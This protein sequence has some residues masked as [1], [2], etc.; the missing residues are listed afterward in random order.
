MVNRYF[1]IKNLCTA[2]PDEELPDKSGMM[3]EK[4][5][6]LH[7]EKVENIKQLAGRLPL[8]GEMYKLWTLNSFNA[9]TFLPFILN[10][11]GKINELI[12]STYSI[13]IRI[14]EALMKLI[15]RGYID[16]VTIF[17]SDSIKSRLPKVHDHLSALVENRASIIQVIYAWN[18]SK[19]SLIQ[20]GD[21][22]FIVDGSGNWGENAQFEQYSFYDS[23]EGFEFFKNAM[24]H[25][26]KR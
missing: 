18:H 13:N 22:Y 11:C 19:I 21:H 4:F 1:D 9:F 7:F 15:D 14:I 3:I 26:A 5:I 24:Y 6:R 25:A 8:P 20:T 12:V 17:I 10:H 2:D 23:P 16:K